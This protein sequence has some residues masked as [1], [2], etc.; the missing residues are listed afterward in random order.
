M[1]VYVYVYV[2]VYMYVNV[3]VCVCLC[4]YV[5]VRTCSQPTFWSWTVTRILSVML[6]VILNS[7][8]ETK[9]KYETRISLSN[10]YG[11]F[12]FN[13]HACVCVCVHVTLW[14][15]VCAFVQYA[16]SACVRA[17]LFSYA[18]EE[19]SDT[20]DSSPSSVSD[21]NSVSDM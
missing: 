18:A 17:Y 14:N 6:F 16:T 9:R 21:L 20:I 10:M 15:I 19:P 11:Y 5:C 4:K 2:Y 7:V 8:T 3:C 1:Y 13:M 12:N